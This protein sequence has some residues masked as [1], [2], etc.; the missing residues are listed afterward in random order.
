MP[1]QLGPGKTAGIAAV[2]SRFDAVTEKIKID[3]RL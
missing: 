1:G 3:S 2:I